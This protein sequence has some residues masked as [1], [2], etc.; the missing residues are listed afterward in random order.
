MRP[1]LRRPKPSISEQ[2]ETG[3]ASR[4][5][6]YTRTPRAI[7]IRSVDAIEKGDF[8]MSE[9]VSER[10]ARGAAWLD[11]TKPGWRDSIEFASLEM[12]SGCRCICGQVFREE[13]RAEHPKCEDASGFDYAT[14]LHAHQ[15]ASG[16]R[17]WE[18]YFSRDHGFVYDARAVQDAYRAEARRL[19]LDRDGSSGNLCLD[20]YQ[21]VEAVAWRELSE[22]WKRQ[23]HASREALAERAAEL[24]HA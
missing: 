16:Q 24:A 22:E 14:E 13:A 5:P 3:T 11:Q 4:P 10:V 17:D 12:K 20:L 9:L 8:E 19:G 2:R 15:V 18:G 23:I 6:E 7:L 21:A 1:L